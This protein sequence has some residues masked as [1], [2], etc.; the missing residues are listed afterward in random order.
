MPEQEGVSGVYYAK[1]KHSRET[2]LPG[3]WE[4]SPVAEVKYALTGLAKARRPI[5]GARGRIN[6]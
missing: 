4:L 3:L 1:L 5:P 2:T 6:F